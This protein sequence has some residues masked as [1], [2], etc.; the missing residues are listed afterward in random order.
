MMNYDGTL[1]AMERSGLSPVHIGPDYPKKELILDS[2]VLGGMM[3][4]RLE[5]IETALA[6]FI[7]SLPAIP[8][9]PGTSLGFYEAIFIARKDSHSRRPFGD[10]RRHYESCAVSCDLSTSQL[11]AP[12]QAFL[13]YNFGL[14]ATQLLTPA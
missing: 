14:T 9:S 3:T 12:V 5:R 10:I 7:L 6:D 1:E 2:S 11:F 8:G 4:K 13:C